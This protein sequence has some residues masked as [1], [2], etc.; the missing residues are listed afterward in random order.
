MG[1]EGGGRGGTHLCPAQALCVPSPFSR[2]SP[3][4]TDIG[5]V[6]FSLIHPATTCLLC[7]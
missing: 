5:L 3:L 1:K 7:V 4:W 6:A 2:P